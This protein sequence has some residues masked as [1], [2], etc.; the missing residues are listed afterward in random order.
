MDLGIQGRVAA[1]AAASRGLGR[2]VALE[3]AK[4]GC[5]VAICARGQDDL[6]RTAAD[7]ATLGAEV[8]AYPVDLASSRG[9]AEFIGKVRAR[10][11]SVDILITN[12]GGPPPG[13]FA[14]VDDS[15]FKKAFELVFL[16]AVRLIREAIPSMKEKRWGRIILLSSVSVR[17]PIEGLVL[18]NVVRPGV[19]ALGKTLSR[20]LAPFGITVNAIL[21]GYILT[22]RL[23]GISC[24]AA[25]SGRTYEEVLSEKAASIP[26]G[27]IGDPREVAALVAFLASE[28]ASYI[29]GQA[30]AV[31]GGL[32]HGI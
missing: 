5:R 2:A 12:S 13:Y 14:D 25:R 26:I 15:S 32:L 19:V 23:K 8:F 29:T 30:I 9:P 16:S 27:R 22:G 21:P 6:R 10:F 24:E 7:I 11:G 20:E 17:E 31:D 18:S 28:R 3:L 1:V 4:E